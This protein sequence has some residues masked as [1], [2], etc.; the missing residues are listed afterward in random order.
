MIAISMYRPDWRDIAIHESSPGWD[1]LSIILHRDC[2]NY[3]ASHF[4]PDLDFGSL[5]EN[6]RMPCKRY[7]NIDLE[8]QSFEDERFDLI[9][10][11]DVLEHV[12][13]PDKA[14]AEMAR[15]LRPGGVTL[16]TV[17]IVRKSAASRRRARLEQGA[18]RHILPPEYHGNPVSPD[19]ALVT[20]DWGFDIASYMTAQS[21]M[22]YSLLR[23]ESPLVGVLGELTE[24]LV[25]LK[26]DTNL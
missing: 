10:T 6:P 26:Q 21:G 20:I 2:S 23:I 17:P 9:I 5:I 3:T 24:V 15:T 18:V 1:R 7:Y 11:Q 25:G 13:H 14:A 12:F 8:Q 4:R 22:A 19:G 16:S